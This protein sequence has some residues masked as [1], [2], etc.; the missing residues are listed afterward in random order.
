MPYTPTNNPYA[1]GD[2]Y[3]YDLKWIVE[4]LKKIDSELASAIQTYGSPL[5]VSTAA[6]MI[7]P[8][9]VYIYLGNEVGYTN[10]DWYYF[11]KNTNLWTSGGA[12]GGYP[13]DTALDSNSTNAVEN[14]VI[15]D[16]LDSVN[17][18]LSDSLEDCGTRFGQYRGDFLTKEGVQSICLVGDYVYVV[19]AKNDATNSGTV[20]RFSLSGNI[21]DTAFTHTVICGHANS[22]CFHNNKFY[23]APVNDY[24]NNTNWYA[25]IEYDA[26]FSN[27][28]I[29]P[30]IDV[31][32]AVSNDPV[33]NN[34][35]C[36]DYAHNLYKYNDTTNALEL[37]A[38]I[39]GITR[40]G[41]FIQDLAVYGDYVYDIAPN[42]IAYKALISENG[43]NV[44][45]GFT[46]GGTDTESKF[47]LGEYEGFEIDSDGNIWILAA[48]K[49]GDLLNGIVLEIV[50]NKGV[51]THETSYRDYPRAS[52]TLSNATRTQFYNNPIQLRHLNQLL[53]LVKPIATVNVQTNTVGNYDDVTIII[54]RKIRLQ[55]GSAYT[56]Y[57]YAMQIFGGDVHIFSQSGNIIFSTTGVPITYQRG[58]VLTLQGTLTI[59]CT[60]T[61][62]FTRYQDD[63]KTWVITVPTLAG[64]GTPTVSGAAMATG[65][66]VG[67]S[68]WI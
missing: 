22:L 11:D 63:G 60:G 34:M 31:I 1:V 43:I 18:K 15:T 67:N 14:R 19:T 45:S 3:M 33:T 7:D 8:E 12:Y 6:E 51:L 68:K 36:V 61:V 47:Y 30:T 53:I 57:A 55:I 49:I 2:P 41:L 23:I 5:V 35:Y 26:A 52:V 28:V 59:T 56:L 16:A 58:A 37:V 32:R 27:P 64:G 42:G 4:R 48:S 9:R 10:G 65:L 46:L 50:A 66:Y 39:D 24:S 17:N 62:L 13:V 38:H 54:D 20:R 21:E 40:A 29:Y 25:L 44:V